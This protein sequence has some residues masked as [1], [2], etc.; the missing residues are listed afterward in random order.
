MLFTNI[1]KLNY[2]VASF[3]GGKENISLPNNLFIES[4]NFILR[5]FRVSNGNNV[6]YLIRE[7]IIIEITKKLIIILKN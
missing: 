2:I 6:N 7:L 1:S 3:M 4:Q 5:N